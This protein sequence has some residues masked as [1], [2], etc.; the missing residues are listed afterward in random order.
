[1]KNP[2]RN[3][4]L[5]LLTCLCSLLL[6]AWIAPEASSAADG[7][8]VPETV[9][10]EAGSFMMGMNTT[11]DGSTGATQILA[12]AYTGATPLKESPAHQVTMSAFNIGKFE[13]TNEEYAGFVN[14]GGYNERSYW[15]IDSDDDEKAEAGWNWKER[16]GRTAPQYTDYYEENPDLNQKGWDL[17]KDP[18]WKDDPYSNQAN[19]PVIGVSWY[20][21]YAYCKWLSE[22]TGDTYRLPTEAEWEYAARGTESLIFPWGNDYL[23]YDPNKFC[24]EPGSGAKANCFVS[25]EESQKILSEIMP[26]METG[27]GTTIPVGSYSEGVSPCGA[28]DMAGNV[29]EWTNDWCQILYYPRRV[30]FGLTEDPPGPSIVLPPFILPYLPF[31]IQPCRAVRSMGF[32]QDPIGASNYSRYGPTYPL[33][34]SHRQFVARFG[35]FLFVGF[36][37]LKEV[38]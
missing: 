38:E 9:P 32:I 23:D 26:S 3:N 14:A 33:R 15:L 20:E 8:K 10:V 35:G 2:K 30:F 19:T 18:Y 24:G 4:V 37:V 21:A 7:T 34:S 22:E 28:Y 11:F 29:A 12:D 25:E 17:T 5:S 16:E 36:R 31:W 6:I 1:M 27:K 13:V